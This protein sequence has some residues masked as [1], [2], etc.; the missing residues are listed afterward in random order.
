MKTLPVVIL[1]FLFS[2]QSLAQVTLVREAPNDS[3]DLACSSCKL[4]ITD[5][6]ITKGQHAIPM[7]MKKPVSVNLLMWRYYDDI[8]KKEVLMADEPF[9]T[10]GV[11]LIDEIPET[12]MLS[13][14]L[15]LRWV[16]SVGQVSRF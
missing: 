11:Q 16:D 8:L 1:Y 9:W 6:A 5:L 2:F 13:I 10:N 4:E 3:F 7:N 14:H 12:E 15:N